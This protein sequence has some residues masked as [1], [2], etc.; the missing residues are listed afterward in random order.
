MPSVNRAKLLAA[1]VVAAIG[2][3]FLGWLF[4][5][6]HDTVTVFVV[7]QDFSAH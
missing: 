3:L 2:A 5:G 6:L 4:F 7:D 1:R